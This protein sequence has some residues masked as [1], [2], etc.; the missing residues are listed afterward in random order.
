MYPTSITELLERNNGEK[1]GG[2][3]AGVRGEALVD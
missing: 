1:G 3:G 2:A